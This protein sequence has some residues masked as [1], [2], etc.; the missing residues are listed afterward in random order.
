MLVKADKIAKLEELVCQYIGKDKKIVDETTTRLTPPGENFGST[1]LK[2]DLI[3][4]NENG[5][6]E[7]V[8]IVAKL[9]PEDELFQQIFNIHVAFNMETAFYEE[10]VPTMQEFQ[11]QRGV[12]EV[13]DFV[14]KFYGS[15]KNINGT[16]DKIDANAVIL[17]ENLKM[18][19][20]YRIVCWYL[21]TV[22][23]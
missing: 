16:D 6:K 23:L 9:I 11:R 2:V 13:I 17:L 22:S 10:I 5:E 18:S 19:G 12:K 1:I 4:E 15:R 3:L 21:H 7:S 8:S 20:K 14:P